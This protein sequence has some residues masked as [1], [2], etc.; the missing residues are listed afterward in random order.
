MA[1]AAASTCTSTFAYP[2]VYS[3]FFTAMTPGTTTTATTTVAA[4][5]AAQAPLLLR[6]TTATPPFLMDRFKCAK[7]LASGP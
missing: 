7:M 2:S 5:D 4:A 3:H 6:T 1:D